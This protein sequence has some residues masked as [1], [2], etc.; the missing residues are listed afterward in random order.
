MV[1][2]PILQGLFGMIIVGTCG[3]EKA[4]VVHTKILGFA[5]DFRKH[6]F[7]ATRAFSDLKVRSHEA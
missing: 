3:S 6:E 7:A 2:K 1:L 4:R 5:S